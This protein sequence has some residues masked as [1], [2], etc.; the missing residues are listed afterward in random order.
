MLIG[1][2]GAARAIAFGLAERKACITIANRT[3]SKAQNLADQCNASAIKLDDIG[4]SKWD[5]ILNT[6]SVGMYPNTTETPFPSDKMQPNTVVFDA[7]YNPLETLLLKN[8]KKLNC[9]CING[10]EMF[11]GQGAR[12]FELWTSVDA[13]RQTMQDVML[14]K[15]YG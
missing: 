1:A 5:V 6:T 10:V 13:P 3:F 2:G 9:H 8:A 11:I 15:V 12:Q 7:I 14:K 4:N